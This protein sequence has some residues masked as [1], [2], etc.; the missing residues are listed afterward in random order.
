MLQVRAY[1]ARL[2]P[3]RPGVTPD[4]AIFPQ[5]NEISSDIRHVLKQLKE[6]YKTEVVIDGGELLPIIVYSPARQE[7]LTKNLQRK[8]FSGQQ[9]DIEEDLGE[10][11]EQ[12]DQYWAARLGLD[13]DV[14]PT[15]AKD[16]RLEAI[17][18]IEERTKG[19]E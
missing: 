4:A 9:Q 3:G 19:T 14:I 13:A 6:K 18:M 5:I 11:F 12:A 10:W 2:V 17:K 1:N 15:G 16:V 7:L 8:L